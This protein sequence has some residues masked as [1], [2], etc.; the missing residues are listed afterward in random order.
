MVVFPWCVSTPG[1]SAWHRNETCT[2]AGSGTHAEHNAAGQSVP[3][4][5]DARDAAGYDQVPVVVVHFRASWKRLG[6]GGRRKHQSQQHRTNH[7]SHL[8]RVQG[9][10][11]GCQ[12]TA[13]AGSSGERASRAGA[14][15]GA[16][17]NGEGMEMGMGTG[18][19]LLRMSA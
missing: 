2:C 13:G 12:R 17:A 15:T 10:T 8:P 9:E 7:Y 5:G 14:H 16:A 6:V 4:I 11:S 19:C 1:V 3:H 18:C